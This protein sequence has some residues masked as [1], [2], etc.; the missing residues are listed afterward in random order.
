[1][2][3]PSMWPTPG[4]VPGAKATGALTQI[5]QISSFLRAYLRNLA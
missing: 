4:V 3:V 5:L 2:Q 1:M